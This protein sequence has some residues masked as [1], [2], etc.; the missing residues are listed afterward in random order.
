MIGSRPRV[1]F[2]ALCCLTAG[3]CYTF[4]P[5]GMNPAMYG[6]QGG[7][8]LPPGAGQVT[9]LDG[10]V[11]PPATSGIS[12]T[13]AEGTSSAPIGTRPGLSREPVSAPNLQ[14]S[15]SSDGSRVPA[16]RDP[17][18]TATDGQPAVRTSDGVL[19]T[20]TG[21]TRIGPED[22]VFLKP[23]VMTADGTN[24][25]VVSADGTSQPLVA[26]QPSSD[27]GRD[28][29]YRW[30]QGDLQYDVQHRTW[31][32]VY[33]YTPF[34][35]RLGGTVTLGGD[36]PFTPSDND[37]IYRVYGSFERTRFDRVGTPIYRVSHVER[38]SR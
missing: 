34:D 33:D 26:R 21:L 22:P 2:A 3:G 7:A 9:C 25:S 38:L 24:E 6:Q 11:A 37:R 29:S 35:D 16:P 18:P 36:L 32:L 8:M 17:A 27:L 31:H 30:V 19:D 14:R 4:N 28:A 13:P 15:G 12:S 20:G 10:T 1:V 5:Y 23:V